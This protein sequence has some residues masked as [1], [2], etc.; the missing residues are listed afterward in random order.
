M[1]GGGIWK[2]QNKRRPG[3]YINF[4]S[5]PKPLGSLGDRGIMTCALPM[6]WGPYGEL[7]Q[8]YANELMTGDSLPKIGVT[9][10]DGEESLPFR[11]ALSG[12]NQ[13]LIFRSDRDGVKA[14]VA[15]GESITIDAKYAGTTGNLVS[16]A[17]KIAVDVCT[18]EISFKGKLQETFVI[19][20]DTPKQLEDLESNW[21][22]FTVTE[23]A[24]TIP[25]LVVTPLVGGTNG[26]VEDTI[27]AD[28]FGLLTSKQWQ[29]MAI[30]SDS[31][32]L[33]PLI[34]NHIKFMRDDLGRKVQAVVYNDNTAD[35]E[36]IIATNQ[37]FKTKAETVPPNLYPL[38]VASHTAGAYINESL[39]SF[40]I[41][42]AVE[43]INPVLENEIADKLSEGW[44][45]LSYRQDGAVCVEQDINTLVTLTPD[46]GYEY[47]KNRLIRCFDEIGNQVPLIFNRSYNGK[48]DNDANGRNL[49]K[50][51][52]I[53]LLE[54]LQGI[55][56]LTNVDGPSDVTVL[57]GEAID[58]VVAE[59][60][61]QGVDSMEKLYMIVESQPQA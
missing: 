44:F 52:L 22:E 54:S 58:G 11:L 39:T 20:T 33:P 6:T 23:A 29:C 42:G 60:L 45:L 56:A 1:A 46:K 16:V 18:I 41:P 28:Y 2:V 9:A 15:L 35:Y 43:I 50:S 32:T 5:K 10:F 19:A 37:G 38:W 61:V 51:E 25:E 8:V 24:L 31:E 40:V 17:S 12:C 26:T 21:V 53:A 47:S 4:R 13:A 27:F 48:V 59:L 49:F 7:I 14:S 3:A 30:D 57:P 34:S 36:G 55:N